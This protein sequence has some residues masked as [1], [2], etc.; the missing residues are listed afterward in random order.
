MP[1]LFIGNLHYTVETRHLESLFE[2]NYD[3]FVSARVIMDEEREQN[4]GYGF[5][6]LNNPDEADAAKQDLD[7]HLLCG[8]EI[9]VKDSHR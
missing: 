1:D 4:K 8:K 9:T 2:L 7:G 6:T 3:S 5:V